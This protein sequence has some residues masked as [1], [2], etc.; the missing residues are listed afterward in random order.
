MSLVRLRTSPSRSAEA[1]LL[2]AGA[3]AMQPVDLRLQKPSED[4]QYGPLVIR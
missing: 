1:I 3:V 4:A 2:G